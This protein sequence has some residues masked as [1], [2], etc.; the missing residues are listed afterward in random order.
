LLN[1]D[2]QRAVDEQLA[3]KGLSK[4]DKGGDLLVG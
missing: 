4:V 2:I 3:Q 1:Q